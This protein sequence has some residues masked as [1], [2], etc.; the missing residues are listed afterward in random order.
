MLSTLLSTII[1]V[2]VVRENKD[3]FY[4]IGECYPNSLQIR[5]SG[6]EEAPSLSLQRE[7]KHAC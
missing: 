4:Q 3:L 6:Q 7:R 1:A 2:L 5:L